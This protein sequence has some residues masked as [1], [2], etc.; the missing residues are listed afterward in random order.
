[1]MVALSYPRK[2]VLDRTARVAELRGSNDSSRGTGTYGR[3]MLPAYYGR[4]SCMLFSSA[5]DPYWYGYGLTPFVSR[6]GMYAS[7]PYGPYGYGSFG[8]GS[9]W[10]QGPV[11][12]VRTEGSR[13]SGQAVKGAGYTRRGQSTGTATR[14][15]VSRPSSSGSGATA[16]SSGSSGSSGSSSSSGG[17]SS[18]RT[19][20]RKP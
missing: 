4:S 3:G 14:T 6:C 9:Y 18:G 15:G 20:H 13:P 7:S 5:Y 1:V 19:A 17:S 10:G 16:R 12:I 8:Y 2:F 11:V